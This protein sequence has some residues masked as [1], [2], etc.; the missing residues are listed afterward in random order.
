LNQLAPGK[1]LADFQAW[2]QGG[3]KGPPPA[4]P[5]GGVT[6]PDVGGHQ[7]FT[8]TLAAGKY[9]LICFVPDKADR[10]PHF[11][12]GMVKEITVS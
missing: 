2:V 9:V 10:K 5:V 6:G 1:T 11:M 7:T 8:A 4:K 3:M 12:H